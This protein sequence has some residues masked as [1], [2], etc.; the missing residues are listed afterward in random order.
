MKWFR[1]YDEALNDPKVQKL[2]DAA[3]KAWVNLLCLAN[4]GKP[5]G[6]INRD[7][8]SYSLRLTE[9]RA[10]KMIAYFIDRDLLHEEGKYLVPHNWDSRQFA[11]DNVTER[12]R[13]HR[14]N[15]SRNVSGNV[16]KRLRGTP[17]DTEAETESDT[18]AENPLDPPEGEGVSFDDLWALVVNRNSGEKKAR[19]A[20]DK[21]IKRESP[22]VILAGLRRH[23]PVWE[24]F[25][26][27][28]KIPHITTW[29]NQERWTV[30]DPIAPKQ[31]GLGGRP[32]PNENLLRPDFTAKR[33]PEEQAKYDEDRRR[34]AEKD[35]ERRGGL[36][37]EE[38]WLKQQQ[39]QAARAVP[40]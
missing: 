36:S 16:P 6:R 5:R 24:Q 12:V 31:K 26:D 9:E 14:R 2:P 22:G 21:A 11:S 15:V 13:E 28:T 19:E 40:R 10:N 3:F 8:I 20:W 34:S 23:L 35:R 37:R 1:F 33:S 38:A 29:L 4:Q 18:E 32:D 17:P 30:Q 7:D 25:E 27:K 39:E